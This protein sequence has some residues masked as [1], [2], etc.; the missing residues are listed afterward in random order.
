MEDREPSQAGKEELALVSPGAPGGGMWQGTAAV[1]RNAS[2]V[3]ASH[4]NSVQLARFLVT[5]KSRL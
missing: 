2:P 4:G 5:R 3:T 1:L